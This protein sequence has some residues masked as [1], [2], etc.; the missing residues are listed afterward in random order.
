MRQREAE[1]ATLAAQLQNLESQLQAR[2]LQLS[3]EALEAVFAAWQ[4]RVTDSLGRQDIQ[5][6]RILIERF[7]VKIELGYDQIRVWYRY[8]L[9]A[10]LI[11]EKGRERETLDAQPIERSLHD[12]DRK[13]NPVHL[14]TDPPPGRKAT[15]TQAAAANQSAR[16][17][18]L[19]SA[20]RRK[21]HHSLASKGVWIKGKKHLGD[22]YENEEE[23]C[24]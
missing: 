23:R 7:I 6:A 18:N 17:G 8:P 10:G 14:R 4:E 3:P 9:E 11:G 24:C 22:L 16:L 20:H 13:S 19:P 2:H 5:A 15:S 1:K 12:M 21:T